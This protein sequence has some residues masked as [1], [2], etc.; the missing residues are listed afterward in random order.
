MPAHVGCDNE[1]ALRDPFIYVFR[2]D[3]IRASN[4]F[5]Q[6]IGRVLIPVDLSTL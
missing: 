4:G 1:P 3:N 6:T 2:N 5:I